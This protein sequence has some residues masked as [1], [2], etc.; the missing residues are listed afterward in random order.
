MSTSKLKPGKS[1]LTIVIPPE[2]LRVLKGGERVVSPGI[3]YGQIG[4]VRY[5]STITWE[6]VIAGP[7]WT[8]SDPLPFAPALAVQRARKVVAK[9]TRGHKLWDVSEVSI[10]RLESAKP[11][12]WFFVVRLDREA[13]AGGVL[14]LPVTFGGLVGTVTKVRDQ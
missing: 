2:A 4:G 3:W 9:L 1:P 11:Q 5:Q 8:L 6:K 13:G 10:Q 7:P 12:R 14:Q